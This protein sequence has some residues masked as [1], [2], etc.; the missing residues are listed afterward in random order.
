MSAPLKRA[1]LQALIDQLTQEFERAK[2]QAQ[3]AADGATHEDNRAEGDKDMRSMEASYIARG[4][5]QRT[6]QLEQAITR[7]S[8]LELHDFDESTPIQTTALVTLRHGARTTRYFLLP[9]A[10][11]ERVTAQGVTVQSLTP[12]SPLGGAL[13]GLSEGDE[14]EV[15]SPQGTR[16]YEVVQVR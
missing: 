1:L 8:H 11:G 9:S 10:G 13:V 2:A 3:D 7:L 16:V 12:S 5:A 14:A 6:A 4:H 15:E